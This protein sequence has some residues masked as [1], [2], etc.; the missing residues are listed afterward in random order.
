VNLTR[1][2]LE[3]EILSCHRH[4]DK[5]RLLSLQ[6]EYRS[7]WTTSAARV[8]REAG[9]VR[10]ATK[11]AAPVDPLPPLVDPWRVTLAEPVREQVAEMVQ[12]TERENK[13]TFRWLIGNWADGRVTVTAASDMTVGARGVVY[14]D[15]DQALVIHD[16]LAGR[17]LEI[18]GG[19][20]SHHFRSWDWDDLMP[21]PADLECWRSWADVF[22]A[23]HL[24]LIARGPRRRNWDLVNGKDEIAAWVALPETREVHA[25]K[26]GYG[27][28]RGWRL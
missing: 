12:R 4:G 8:S 13:E 9:T 15:A 26:V 5:E 7:C 6:A 28:A 19:L 25:A 20:H 23:P 11:T 27:R 3:H 1:E 14:P 18:V 16:R 2:Q 10:L 24:G 17:G 21:S 22:D